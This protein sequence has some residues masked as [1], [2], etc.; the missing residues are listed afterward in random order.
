MLA[1][2]RLQTI[3]YYIVKRRETDL[4]VIK[5]RPLLKECRR[6]E[7]LQGSPSCQYWWEQEYNIAGYE[8]AW[9]QNQEGRR[10]TPDNA[11]NCA[12]PAGDGIIMRCMAQKLAEKG[13]H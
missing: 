2:V 5:G 8:P 13:G 11:N 4:K 1:A 7:R 6:T 3:E 9:E 10:Q 12:A